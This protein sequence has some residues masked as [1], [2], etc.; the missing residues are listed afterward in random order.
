[1]HRWFPGAVLISLALAP[2]ALDAD[3]PGAVQAQLPAP[4]PLIPQRQRP[5]VPLFPVPRVVV[6]NTPSQAG[7][8]PRAPSGGCAGVVLVDPKIDPKFVRRVPDN[9]VKYT[10]RVV[11]VPAPCR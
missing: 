11:P 8:V 5:R 6:P 2:A 4:P 10:I 3:V 1:M 9:G 7:F